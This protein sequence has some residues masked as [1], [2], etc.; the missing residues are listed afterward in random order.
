MDEI[1]MNNLKKRLDELKKKIHY[2]KKREQQSR[3]E[4]VKETVIHVHLP[5][6]RFTGG[7]FNLS[8]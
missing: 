7:G 3:D 4:Q 5:D 6:K 8:G 2:Q 1:Q